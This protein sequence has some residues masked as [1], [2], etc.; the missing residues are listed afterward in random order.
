MF[1]V[2]Q[3]ILICR[4][5]YVQKQKIRQRLVKAIFSPWKVAHMILAIKIKNC[6]CVIF[7]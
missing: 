6:A 1:K 3:I 2:Y 5:E 4:P 7:I